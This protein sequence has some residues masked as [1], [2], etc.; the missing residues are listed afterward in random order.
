MS[1]IFNEEQR[2]VLADL[3]SSVVMTS[4]PDQQAALVEF[5]R[6]LGNYMASDDDGFNGP[7]FK[8]ACGLA[9]DG[10]EPL[11]SPKKREAAQTWPD[12]AFYNGEGA[13]LIRLSD[14]TEVYLT[15]NRFGDGCTLR[16]R[17]FMRDGGIRNHAVLTFSPQ[18]G[19]TRYRNLPSY[20]NRTDRSRQVRV[21]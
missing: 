12:S 19:V 2:E 20:I 18:D 4:Q 14:G 21:R 6:H 15:R 8:Q 17:Q 1:H 5:V 3:I 16:S 7:E 13:S 11:F 10:S 9:L